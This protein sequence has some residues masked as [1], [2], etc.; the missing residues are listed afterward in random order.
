MQQ[1][2]KVV[3]VRNGAEDIKIRGLTVLLDGNEVDNLQFG[4]RLEVDVAAGEHTLKVT[5]T[6]FTKTAPIKLRNGETACFQ[7]GNKMPGLWALMF[8]A[9]GVVPYQVFLYRVGGEESAK[10]D[11]ALVPA[12]AL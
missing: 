7:A 3:V 8:F 12:A 1:G 4:E 5:N 6:L 9:V 10:V 11:P 2:A